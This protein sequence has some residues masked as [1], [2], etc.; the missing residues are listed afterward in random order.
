MDR[1]YRSHIPRTLREAYGHD[2][3]LATHDRRWLRWPRAELLFWVPVAA[4]CMWLMPSAH[5]DPSAE[6]RAHGCTPLGQAVTGEHVWQCLGGEL[7]ISSV[8]PDQ[9]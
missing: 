3:E 2:V 1:E 4:L 5:K 6:L 9:F 7:R 8:A